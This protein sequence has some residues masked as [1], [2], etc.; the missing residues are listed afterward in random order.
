M[1]I[2]NAKC[3]MTD[4][5]SKFIIVGTRLRRVRSNGLSEFI[6]CGELADTMKTLPPLRGPPSLKR[7][8]SVSLR[9]N[10]Q[11]FRQLVAPE[12]GDVKIPKE[13]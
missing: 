10:T 2:Q 1:Q 8:G 7:D 6:R 11:K 12:R 5:K 9:Y 4:E 3:K 13:F